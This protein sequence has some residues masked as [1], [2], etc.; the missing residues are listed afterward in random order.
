MSLRRNQISVDRES[1]CM[2]D[3]CNAPNE[4]KLDLNEG[5]LLSDVLGKVA[6]YLPQMSDVIW[7]ER[8]RR[9]V[10]DD[11]GIAFQAKGENAVCIVNI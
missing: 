11:D 10:R 4:K 2:G 3:D 8:K 1:V 6:E 7:A 9:D 5:D